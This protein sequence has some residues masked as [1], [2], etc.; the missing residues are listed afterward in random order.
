MHKLGGERLESGPAERDL[1]VWVD[2][3]LNR[4]Q[5]HVLAARGAKR[6]LWC[7]KHSITA[8]LGTGKALGHLAWSAPIQPLRA[9]PAGA[10]GSG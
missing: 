4:S 7:V 3:K 10:A 2:G 8:L 6:V 9:H 1:G 5:Q